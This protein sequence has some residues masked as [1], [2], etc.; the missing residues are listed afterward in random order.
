MQGFEDS[1]NVVDG[2]E[3]IHVSTRTSKT[4]WCNTAC[5][6]D[7]LTLS[8]LNKIESITS[9]PQSHGEHLQLLRYQTG[10]FYQYVSV[11]VCVF[12][13]NLLD[14]RIGR[15]SLCYNL[16]SLGGGGAAIIRTHH[17]YIEYERERQQGV[18][19]LVRHGENS[20]RKTIVGWSGPHLTTFICCNLLMCCECL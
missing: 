20:S 12:L 2:E 16:I 10:Q 3:M 17:D 19:V 6:N 11:C 13:C 15:N 8:V 1:Q 9:I 18:R 14:A 5:M 4:A 7:P